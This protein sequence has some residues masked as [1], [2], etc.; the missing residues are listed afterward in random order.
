MKKPLP[1]DETPDNNGSAYAQKNRRG[2][3]ILCSPRQG[4]MLLT[5]SV[6]SRLD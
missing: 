3:Q 2:A 1:C 6:N 4:M 5:N